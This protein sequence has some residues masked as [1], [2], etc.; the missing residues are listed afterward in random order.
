MVRFG[1]RSVVACFA[2]AMAAAL[3]SVS[4]AWAAPAEEA[5][6]QA[7]EAQQAEMNLRA[8]AEEG[9]LTSGA[10]T[11]SS[12]EGDGYIAIPSGSRVGDFYVE[13]ADDA[14][15]RTVT[16]ESSNESVA[17][18][19]T[20]SIEDLS[21]WGQYVSFTSE[22]LGKAT[23]TITCGTDKV[24]FDVLHYGTD[25]GIIWDAS[26]YSYSQV[27]LQWLPIGGSSGCYIQRA[28]A[29]ASGYPS[30]D[31]KTVKTLAGADDDSYYVKAF[32]D[33]PWNKH[34]VYRVV[35]FM[36]F[37]GKRFLASSIS[38]RGANQQVAFTMP[39]PD[40]S[41]K[42][43]K[44]SG[45]K[46]LTVSWKAE[47]GA[48]SYKLYRAV[49]ASRTFKRISTTTKKSFVDKKV[50]PGNVYRY[51]VEVTFDNGWK[52]KTNSFA[53]LLPKKS[54]VLRKG[55]SKM[56]YWAGYFHGAYDGF[57]DENVQEALTQIGAAHPDR[58]FYYTQGGKLYAAHYYY[59]NLKIYTLTTGG[60]IKSVKTVK[61]P[62]HTEWGGMYHA[63]D[64]NNYV[65]IGFKNPKESKTK[66]VVKVI[67]YNKN[68]KKGKAA[69][70]KGKMDG[71]GSGINTPFK[72]GSPGFGMA[73]DGTL[74]MSMSRLMFKS[75]DGV[76]HQSSIGFAIDTKKMKA[77]RQSYSTAGHSFNQLVQFQDGTLYK[78]E[79]G[80]AYPRA[81]QVYARDGYGTST[82]SSRA[83]NAFEFDGRSGQ[84][85]TG[86]TMGGLEVGA[87]YTLVCGTAQPHGYEGLDAIGFGGYN[88][89]VFVARIDRST[90]ESHV[91]WIT[92]FNPDGKKDAVECR[93]VKISEDRFGL[94][95]TVR[96]QKTWEDTFYYTVISNTG[97]KISTKAYKNMRFSSATQPVLM[98]GSIYWIEGAEH[99]GETPVLFRIPAL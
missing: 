74:Y 7:Q 27:C 9:V 95:Y 1:K 38:S 48:V 96:N 25:C 87:K 99:V 55:L 4:A 45:A 79:H 19:S 83:T 30:G 86:A 42:S 49:N 14:A 13:L 23:I 98:N 34:Y 26:K 46:A 29:D 97:K 76:N 70:I 56:E 51:Y 66:T 39:S 91:N 5:G 11:V 36:D 78:A 85:D 33:A 65:A 94:L 12:L 72:A 88:Q 75:S 6:L 18:L 67:K 60:A 10:L 47:K 40:A 59:R 41:I 77:Q 73:D 62:K 57:V 93:M 90:G 89:N 50:K 61:L 8:S 53:R 32:V 71:D 17:S 84:N 28:K 80:D 21:Q 2:I 54:S 31:F 68:W 35:P 24:S 82:V 52:Y 16:F 64:G 58:M 20:A 81:I 44:K 15:T 43:V 63:P 37:H 92:H 22:G 3:G 69:S